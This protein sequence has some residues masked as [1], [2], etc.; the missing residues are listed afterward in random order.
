[1][2]L[3]FMK[4]LKA[5]A[6]FFIVQNIV[7]WTLGTLSPVIAASC[8]GPL[9]VSVSPDG[10]N[11]QHSITLPSKAVKYYVKVTDGSGSTCSTNFDANSQYCSPTNSCESYGVASPWG[12]YRSNVSG[13]ARIDLDSPINDGTY[14]SQFR[15]AGTNNSWSNQISII[16]GGVNNNP[17]VDFSEYFPSKPGFLYMFN[18]TNYAANAPGDI[19]TGKTRLQIEREVDW[20]SFK[21]TPWRFTKDSAY[22]Y[23]SAKQVG[24]TLPEENLRWMVASPNYQNANFPQFNNLFWVVG[25]KRYKISSDP[26][27]LKDIDPVSFS[28]LTKYQTTTGNYPAYMIAPKSTQVPYLYYGGYS[29]FYSQTTDV[30]AC[31]QVQTSSPSNAGWKIRAEKINLVVNNGNFHYNGDGLRVDYFEA[32]TDPNGA[33]VGLYKNYLLR[34]TWFF[35]KNIGPVRI[36]IRHFNSYFGAMPLSVA[37]NCLDSSDCLDDSI[38]PDMDIVLSNYY[39]NPQFTVGVSSD[40]INYTQAI[41]VPKNQGYHLKLTNSDFT[42][43]LETKNVSTGQISKWLWVDNG[44]IFITPSQLANLANGDYKFSFRVWAPEGNFPNETKISDPTIPWSNDIQI[45]LTEPLV[46]DISGDGKNDIFDYS[47][48]VSAFGKTGVSGFSAVDINTD[49]KVD[50]FDYTILVA[51]FGK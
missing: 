7:I 20:C 25:D 24:I 37:P 21:T 5:C 9:A 13:I 43:Y 34:E 27:G 3:K 10:V 29:S 40:G 44:Q 49:G 45:T 16:V 33:S 51:N 31:P 47:I 48:L 6:V 15:I 18:S 39:L 8:T 19:K 46:G 23:W 50:I 32:D 17:T 38:T 26:N 2:H 22:A 30:N 41:T 14:N 36:Q 4:C 12:V 1:M 35:A 28:Q 11:F 42:G